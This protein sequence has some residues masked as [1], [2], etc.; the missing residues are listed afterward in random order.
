MQH[1]ARPARGVLPGLTGQDKRELA[2]CFEVRTGL[3]GRC[4][5]FN[6][7]RKCLWRPCGT[8]SALTG[9]CDPLQPSLEVLRVV[10]AEILS[11]TRDPCS[12]D[13]PIRGP[14]QR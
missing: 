12:D 11:I 13:A 5:V 7:P 10:Y 6:G 2:P 8:P 3:H 9:S 1:V 4:H 14:L